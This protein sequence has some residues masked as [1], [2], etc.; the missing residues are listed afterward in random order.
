MYKQMHISQK[1]CFGD[2]DFWFLY[3]Q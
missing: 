1:R 2:T 3:V